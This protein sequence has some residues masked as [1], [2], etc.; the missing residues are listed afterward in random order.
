MPTRRPLLQ[1]GFPLANHFPELLAAFGASPAGIPA[2]FEK[3]NEDPLSPVGLRVLL[4]D[5]PK[6]IA[7]IIKSPAQFRIFQCQFVLGKVAAQLTAL[8]LILGGGR[9]IIRY[10]I[11]RQENCR[12]L[13]SLPVLDRIDKLKHK[14]F[15]SRVR[16]LGYRIPQKLRELGEGWD[17]V[18]KERLSLIL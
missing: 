5:S 11:R 10:K 9:I 6:K 2:Q 12:A 14:T 13:I 3:N 1:K 8:L 17:Q 15:A 7:L 18:V 4:P 16:A